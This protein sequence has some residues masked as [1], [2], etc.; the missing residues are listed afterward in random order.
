MS[1]RYCS[2]CKIVKPMDEFA[3]R[4]AGSG[5]TDADRQQTCRVCRKLASRTRRLSKEPEKLEHPDTM[6]CDFCHGEKVFKDFPWVRRS[7]AHKHPTCRSCM[8][9]SAYLKSVKN[10]QESL[11]GCHTPSMR[12]VFNGDDLE[13]T[14]SECSKTWHTQQ[15][16]PEICL[17]YGGRDGRPRY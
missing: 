9:G 13:C 14:R 15:L 16:N 10:E 8:R 5:Q 17:G 1:N 12:H 2:K 4:R 11:C 6:V 7:R 3:F